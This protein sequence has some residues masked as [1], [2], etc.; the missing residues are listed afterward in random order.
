MSEK[1]ISY[2][3]RTYAEF[4]NDIIDKTRKYYSDIF[5]NYNDASIGMWF[6]DVVA[7][8]ADTL[9]YNI[10]RV[11]QETGIESATTRDSL[12]KL[13]KNNGVKVPGK[14][15]AIV[16]VELSCVVPI[17]NANSVDEDGNNQ[18]L[19]DYNYAPI[20]KRGSLFTNG[21]ST[22]ELYEDVDFSQQFDKNGISNRKLIPVRNYNGIITGYEIKKLS[23]AVAGQSKIHKKYISQN[24]I[25]PFMTV[26]LDDENATNVESIILKQGSV[27]NT[28]ISDF[29]VD[30]ES[31]EGSNGLPVLRYFEVDNLAEQYRFGYVDEEY[32]DPN[33]RLVTYNPVWD[34]V[35][36]IEY[37]GH[38][39]PIRMACRGKWK[40]LKNKFTTEFTESGSLKITF[41]SGV[42]NAYGQ[43]PDDATE[44]TKYMMARMEANDYMGVLPEP[45]TTMFILYHV[46]GGEQTN[47]AK[48]TLNDIVYASVEISGNCA[49]N[50]DAR[51]KAAVKSSLSVTNTTP[52]YGGKDEPSDE[53]LKLLIKYNS[54]AQNRCVTVKDYFAMISRIEPKYGIPFRY[55]VVEEN[56]KIVVYSLGI[57]YQGHLTDELCERVSENIKEFLS[58]YKMVNDLV[59]IMPGRIINVSFSIDVFIDKTYDRSEVVKRIIDTAYEYM[60]VRHHNMGDDIFLGDLEKEISKL[61]GV[62][63]LIALRCY[64]NAGYGYSGTMTTQDVYTVYDDTCNPSTKNPDFVND[65]NEF[66]LAKSDKTLFGDASAMF[67]IKYKEK[68]IVVNVKTR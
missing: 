13:A 51:K 64:N 46:G 14:K 10:D 24:D 19:P 54:A 33:T 26:E 32:D 45:N 28:S 47:I 50:L 62:V 20:M 37:D 67:E 48:G 12:L 5:D 35:D 23:I 52:S 6:I 55:N 68:D 56:N 11:Y 63:N 42:R 9:S 16:E 39:E 29:F 43:I 53:E 7:D 49:D 36:A 21:F 2:L 8:I 44:F 1:V 61:D 3:D 57:D 18:A 15:C 25:E 27:S 38:I 59:E 31:F 60:D 41:G 40:R 30:R 34:V 65:R 4:K 22:F 17:N 58:N 66:N